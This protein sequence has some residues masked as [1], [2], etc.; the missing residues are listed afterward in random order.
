MLKKEL[1]KKLL[2]EYRRKQESEARKFQAEQ[3]E[4]EI[5]KKFQSTTQLYKDL[6]EEMK[7]LNINSALN[8]NFGENEEDI[9][10][11]EYNSD[12]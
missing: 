3:E 11:S 2:E 7:N 4:I 10:H 5:V 9:K 8:I 12:K 1:E 6:M